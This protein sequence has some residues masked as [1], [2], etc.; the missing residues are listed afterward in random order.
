MPQIT[1]WL[2][3]CIWSHEIKWRGSITLNTQICFI[4]Y[5]S[6]CDCGRSTFSPNMPLNGHWMVFFFFFYSSSHMHHKYFNAGPKAK[7]HFAI[8]NAIVFIFHLLFCHFDLECEGKKQPMDNVNWKYFEILLSKHL[9]Q[10]L[11]QI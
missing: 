4:W 10:V 3:F 7:Y 9:I 8:E 1:V 6:H 11:V 2:Y 5:V